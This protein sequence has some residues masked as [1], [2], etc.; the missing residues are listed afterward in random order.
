LAHPQPKSFFYRRERR[1]Q[2]EFLGTARHAP[3]LMIGW[4]S[5]CP[6]LFLAYFVDRFCL[7]LFPRDLSLSL[8]FFATFASLRFKEFWANTRFAPTET[9]CDLRSK[10]CDNQRNQRI[11]AAFSFFPVFPLFVLRGLRV[12]RGLYSFSLLI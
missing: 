2:G 3:T 8:S 11:A 6:L 7:C 4:N 9:F 5:S 10:I 1:G 12:L